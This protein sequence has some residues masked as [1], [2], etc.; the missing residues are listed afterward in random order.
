MSV[1]PHHRVAL[2][3]IGATAVYNVVEGVIAISSGLAASS[4]TLVAF[5]ADS[6]LEVLAAGAVMWRLLTPDEEEGERREQRALRIVGMTFL[7]LAAAVVVQGGLALAERR[8]AEESLVGIILLALSLSIMPAVALAKLRT[9]ARRQLPALAA[10]ARETIAC[11]YLS[12]TAFVG[13]VATA[14]A[15][16]WWIDPAAALLMVPWL[17]REGLEALRGDV[18]FEGTTLCSCRS[19]AFGLRACSSACCRIAA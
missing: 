11:S 9:A 2:S 4:L 1:P 12:L 8:G 6:Y 18:C 10:E 7:L 19:C 14:L 16:W 15:G 17:L 5:G 13:L 3:L